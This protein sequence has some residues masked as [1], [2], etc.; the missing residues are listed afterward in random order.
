MVTV[1]TTDDRGVVTWW[2]VCDDRR[3]P[4][5]GRSVAAA[6]N[7]RDLAAGDNP[8]DDRML[9]VII[10]GN[11]SPSAVMQFQRRIGQ[12]IGNTVLSELRANRTDDDSL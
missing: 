6:S 3:L 11:Q 12:W 9:P 1:H 2:Q 8:A 10:R 4:W 7:S 5:V